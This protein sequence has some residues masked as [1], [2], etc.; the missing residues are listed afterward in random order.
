LPAIPGY[1]RSARHS[2]DEPGATRSTRHSSSSLSLMLKYRWRRVA[3]RLRPLRTRSGF[4]LPPLSA[5]NQARAQHRQPSE[6]EKQPTPVRAPRGVHGGASEEVPPRAHG[7]AGRLQTYKFEGAARGDS[8][9]TGE[10]LV[11]P[12]EVIPLSFPR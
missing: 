7:R 4:E 6:R 1:G 8:S 10:P 12:H 5:A 2:I 9:R 3:F 11:P